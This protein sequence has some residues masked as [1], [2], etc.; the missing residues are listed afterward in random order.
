V[1]DGERANKI[2]AQINEIRES[3]AMLESD[4]PRQV[5]GFALSQ[6]SKLPWKVLLYREALIWRIVELGRSA[7]ENFLSERI[8][9]G[10]VLTRAAVEA[11]AALWYLSAKVDAVVDS[12]I[13]GDVDEYLMKLAMGTATGW[14]ETDTS[15]DVLTMPRPI[16]IGTFLKQVEKDIEGFS[17]QYGV[18]SEYAHPNWAG[19]V[20]LYSST[21]KQKA[22][23]D[24]GQNMRKA[25]NAEAIGVG[26]LGVA[27]K[28]FH[29]KY[30][31][32]SD[33][34]PA[35]ISVC[36]AQSANQQGH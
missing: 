34:I 15:T 30:N 31:R 11:S 10:V 19:T 13:V 23:T 17:H 14:P 18:L 21:N 20:L 27:L 28:M 24:F 5:D 25:E 32:I 3:L 35:F 12:K 16:K 4:L 36:E 7:L 33:L 1:S 26:N 2:A 29:V 8:V 6:K 22:I 9:S